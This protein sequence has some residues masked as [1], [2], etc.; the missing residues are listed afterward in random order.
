M[1]A[2]KTSTILQCIVGFATPYNRILIRHA[3]GATEQGSPASLSA[4]FNFQNCNDFLLI[5]W[6][7]SLVKI[8]TALIYRSS[9]T[10]YGGGHSI[11]NMNVNIK[12][13][14][15]GYQPVV[16]IS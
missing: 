3:I 12:K 15:R 16:F 6:T 4:G 14:I 2:K 10:G 8:H 9:R 5:S 11:L 7:L 1:N 13:Y